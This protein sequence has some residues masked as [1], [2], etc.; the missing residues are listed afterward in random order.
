MQTGGFLSTRFARAGQGLTLAALLF[1]VSVV[2]PAP[3]WA[4][5]DPGTGNILIYICISILTA[6]LYFAKTAW[7]GLRNKFSA[8]PVQRAATRSEELVLFSE[9]KIYWSTFRPIVA[10]LLERGYPFRYLSMDIEDPGLAIESPH[11]N[12]R[13]I[14]TGSAAFARAAAVRASVM[15]QTT[16]NIGTP[17]YPMPIP[18]HVTCLAHVLH[19]V[20]GI[21]LYYKNAHDTCNV[22]FLM[23][24]G[25]H[26][27]IRLLEK[28]R[29]LPERECVS[30]G[31]PC[32]DELARTVLPKNGMS[33][34]PVILVAP[35]WGEKNCLTYCGTEFIHWLTEAGYNVIIRP[36]P[37]SQ[38]AEQPFI[39]ALQEEFG[40]D[41]HV[42]IDLDVSGGPSLAAADL[43]ISDKSG[44]RFDFAF[45]YQRP[46]LTLDIPMRNR[47]KF[48]ISDL[49]YVWEDD[50][51]RRLGPVLTPETLRSM[52][53]EAFLES[54]AAT[55]A[56]EG[57]DLAALRD[58]TIANFGCS[59]AFIADWV[60][61]KCAALAAAQAPE[62]T[63][64]QIPGQ[65][66]NQAPEGGQ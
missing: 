21:S 32:L 27:S 24:H 17:G 61:A 31:V 49:E 47:E 23:G 66:P 8:T 34:P 42:R 62:Q 64:S 18:R 9:G 20:G 55:L 54:V 59:G 22:I 26:E 3:A 53:R 38:K 46:V 33:D 5:L 7:Y 51:E 4:Y 12:S 60:I 58:A 36:H 16:A 48:E 43:L 40:R 41:P 13:F 19:G 35:S 29:G 37:F 25:D 30:A 65:A 44:V 11:M 63:L 6:V 10:A 57:K 15:L 1:G 45:L 2:F 50:V 14:G 52:T 28:K 39:A 56:M